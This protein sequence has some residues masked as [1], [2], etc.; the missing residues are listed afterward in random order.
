[1]ENF[2]FL[3]ALSLAALG[4]SSSS[5]KSKEFPYGCYWVDGRLKAYNGTPS[6]R[7]WPRGTKRLLGVVS[8][9]RGSENIDL[10]ANVRNLDFRFG[11]DIWGEFKVC[12]LDPRRKGWMRMVRMID[13]RNVIV[14]DN[15]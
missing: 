1:M 5:A 11:R 7:I 12:P 9:P 15:R 6:P 10:P 14:V 4:T 13:A 2:A 3:V 8:W